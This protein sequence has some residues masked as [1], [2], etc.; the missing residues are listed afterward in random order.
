VE[1]KHDT[2]GKILELDSLLVYCW[3]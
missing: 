2:S 1:G 3:K